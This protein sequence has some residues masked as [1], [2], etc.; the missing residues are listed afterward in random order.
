MTPGRRNLWLAI[1]V[2]AVGQA[3]VLGWMIWD[4][5]S[6]L[7]NGREI[8][9]EVIPVDPRSL[10]RGDYVVLGYDVSRLELPPGTEPPETGSPYFVTLKK[11]TGDT[12]QMVGGGSEAPSGTTPDEVVLKGRVEYAAKAT[13]ERPAQVGVHYGIESFFVPEGTGR[14][15]EKMVGEKKLSALI[16]VDGNGKAAIKGLLSE[17]K[18][19]YEEPL[20]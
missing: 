5:V 14:E 2:V 15:L 13:P 9:L 20:L 10:F 12:W 4:R 8:V 1:A 16:A 17:G 19:V 6:L 11:S 18:R 3:A 7:A